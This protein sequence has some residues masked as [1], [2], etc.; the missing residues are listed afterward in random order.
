M[1]HKTEKRGR[2]KLHYLVESI[3]SN[4]GWK[5]IKIYLGSNLTEG[6]VEEAIRRKR[7]MLEK[8]QP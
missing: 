1:Y 3:R 6:R 7:S 5:K 8:K 2:N 4:G